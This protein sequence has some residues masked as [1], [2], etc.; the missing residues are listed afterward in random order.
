[1]DPDGTRGFRAAIVARARFIE[2]LVVEQ[3]GHGVAQYVMLGA[4]LD[5]FAQ[6][7]PRD[8]RRACGCSRSTSPARRPGSGNG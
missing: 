2:D 6:R 5:T 4:G 3:A 8:R 1:M 7:R